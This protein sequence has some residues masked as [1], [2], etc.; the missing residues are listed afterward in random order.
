MKTWFLHSPG[1]QETSN[2]ATLRTD[3]GPRFQ[4]NFTAINKLVPVD[5]DSWNT[6]NS[7]G[8]ISQYDATFKWWQWTVDYIIGEV[9]PMLNAS[10]P[11]AA[12]EKLTAGLVKSICTTAQTYC[13]G[14]NQQY[15]SGG[16]CSDYLTKK[17]RFGQAYEL[18]SSPSPK[19]FLF[20]KISRRERWLMF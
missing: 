5:I 12:V 7:Q 19:I 6:Y 10:T 18:G 13:K 2:R 11:A 9:M 15:D 17:V 4:F 14:P 1:K 3:E 8:Q 16:E 20:L